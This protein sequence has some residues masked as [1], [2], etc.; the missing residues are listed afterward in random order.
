MG[1]KIMKV[2]K[3]H[4]MNRM[5][6]GVP[7]AA[8]LL[9]LQAGCSGG[10]VPTGG[11]Q[12][13]PQ[14]AAPERPKDRMPIEGSVP[15]PSGGTVVV[16]SNQNLA[17]VSEAISSQIVVVDLTK[18]AETKRITL[19]PGDEPG[20]C[21]E[22]SLPTEF[23]CVLRTGSAVV[24]FRTDQLRLTPIQRSYVCNEPRGLAFAK[25]DQ[26]LYVACDGG[27]LVTVETARLELQPVK[28]QKLDAGLHDVQLIAGSGGPDEEVWVSRRRQAKV[29][30][31]NRQTG[32]QLGSIEPPKNSSPDAQ[33][34]TASR[35]ARLPDGTGAYLLHEYGGLLPFVYYQGCVNC[36]PTLMELKNRQAASRALTFRTTSG[37]KL[38]APLD[39]A[40]HNSG[41]VAVIAAGNRSI[42][43]SDARRPLLIGPPGSL[44]PSS[45]IP[46]TAMPV[47]VAAY[48]DGFVVQTIGQA[49][50]WI[51]PNNGTPQAIRLEKDLQPI[52]PLE[53]FYASSSSVNLACASCHPD[54]KDDGHKWQIL[55]T[56]AT[57]R[58]TLSLRGMLAGRSMFRRTGSD[59]SLETMI[60]H[61][62]T[63]L[64]PRA[65]VSSS[66]VQEL[67]KWMLTLRPTWSSQSGYSQESLARGENLYKASCA[68]CHGTDKPADGKH[69]LAG[70]PK[71]LVAPFLVDLKNHAP[72]F[73]DGCAKTL[74]Q[75]MDGTCSSAGTEHQ[76][77]G[78]E[79]DRQALLDYL[80]TR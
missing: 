64:N 31:L 25:S 38:V 2:V 12:H 5:F 73:T 67:A 17:V 77:K 47:A 13:D 50:L 7:A 61:D 1:G 40:I 55:S 36:D 78:S 39:L 26:R 52:R 28:S 33:P 71:P 23:F 34:T 72:Y 45:A 18:Q 19:R 79:A 20:Q 4:S 74:A 80:Q 43:G 10:V 68:S 8:W 56:D 46:E 76:F 75:T 63:N 49:S 32:E 41:T 70:Q 3:K 69:A 62:L 42:S 9:A 24:R 65:T 27:E 16:S 53:L 51:V 60:Q 29:Y 59:S 35:L 6:T 21:V 11:A 57:R 37:E 30:K 44:Q 15:I 58:R 14:P 54:G 22:G 66:D 48:R